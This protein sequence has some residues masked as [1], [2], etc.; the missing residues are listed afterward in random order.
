MNK[1]KAWV[2]CAILG[3]FLLTA[4]GGGGGGTNP[5]PSTGT[6]NNN[7]GDTG[8]ASL[9]PAAPALGTVLETDATILAPQTA[10]ATWRFY[11]QQFSSVGTALDRYESTY[12]LTQSG[13]EWRMS[14]SN[15]GNDGPDVMRFVVSN[16]QVQQVETVQFNATQPAEDVRVTLLR[17]PVRAGDQVV[18]LTKRIDGVPD[19]DG[20][21][22]AESMDVAVYTRVIGTERVDTASGESLDA[23]RVETHILQRVTPSKSGQPGP[24]VDITGVDW[25]ARGLGWVARD[26]P[27]ITTDGQIRIG[28]ERLVGAD[29]GTQGYGNLGLPAALTNP[30]SSPEQAG[31]PLAMQL[32]TGV[33]DGDRA[34]LISSPPVIDFSYR[35]LLTLL[36]SRGEVQWTRL[37]PSG[38]RFG[39]PLGTGW[40]LW[41]NL[42]QGT[43]PIFRLD[44]E[45]KALT[46][47]AQVLDLG[48][49]QAERPSLPRGAIIQG[50]AQSLWVLML[51]GD[52]QT[53]A[54]GSVAPREGLV[55]R[56]Y[57][58]NGQPI[59]SA[60]VLERSQAAGSFQG[61]YSLAVRQGKALVSWVSTNGAMPRL[62]L[63]S[64]SSNGT[65]TITQADAGAL[66]NSTSASITAAAQGSLLQ[67]G[68]DD[69]FAWVDDTLGL[70]LLDATRSDG[71]LPS[72]PL[73]AGG[74]PDTQ[75]ITR[76]DLVLRWTLGAPSQ[77]AGGVGT[78]STV[79]T[80]QVHRRGQPAP[81]H[82][83]F[84][85]TPPRPL[86]L[87]MSDR[88]LII[89]R[90]A[91]GTGW[92]VEQVHY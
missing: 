61:S 12:Q 3:V 19:Q 88:L 64:V 20:D 2:A 87:P 28:K 69:R 84:V 40:V 83:T 18:A 36:N 77:G 27:S 63:A 4:C 68:N 46:A 59:T 43:V 75:T 8:A 89:N 47:T 86:I 17:S 71:T 45:G 51:R 29:V 42:D 9:V 81:L 52:W 11:G 73:G 26:Q 85:A 31:Q 55:V 90:S 70:T 66:G 23:I 54:D 48:L 78:P 35:P 44:A 15:P 76:G 74:I 79:L 57:D 32:P 1:R 37:G 6:G 7:P 30:V 21:G 49:P 33:V 91:V 82:Q 92:V 10:G 13:S 65:A 62:M 80:W 56:G 53:N 67:W 22:R 38:A 25:F 72:L 5:G 50:D 41:G 60:I 39:S 14:G 24:V 34:L 16:G 58:L